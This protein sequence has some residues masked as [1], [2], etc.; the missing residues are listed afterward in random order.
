MVQQIFNTVLTFVVSGVLG[1]SLKT[2]KTYKSKMKE[3]GKEE[4]TVKE[5]LKYLIQSNLTNTYYTYAEI[6]QIP[7]YLF[8]NWVNLFRIYKAL[9]GN[10][11]VDELYRRI[12]Q[13]Q[14][15]HTDIINNN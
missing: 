12:T 6:Q 8:K 10:E 3:K 9:G 1:Y 2:I 7:D 11:Y 13:W 5:A 15:I 14:I 4:Q